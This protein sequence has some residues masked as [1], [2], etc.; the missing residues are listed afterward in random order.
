MY[1]KKNK[2]RGV[3]TAV[4]M[5][6]AMFLFVGLF[7]ACWSYP[8]HDVSIVIS[9]ADGE[10][11]AQVANRNYETNLVLDILRENNDVLQIPDADWVETPHGVFINTFVGVTA[12]FSLDGTWWRFDVDG[13]MAPLGVS[14]MRVWNGAVI[15][16]TL[17]AG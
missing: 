11:L 6:L 9:G 1:T 15:S 7:A 2:K 17:V 3:V 13:E 8:V 14:S 4:V 16:F 10:V 12:N 5:S